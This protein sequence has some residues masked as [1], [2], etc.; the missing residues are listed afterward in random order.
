[1]LH[2]K[3]VL[4]QEPENFGGLPVSCCAPER[5][6]AEIIAPTTSALRTYFTSDYDEGQVF[7]HEGT[8]YYF[9][10]HKDI[11][12]NIMLHMASSILVLELALDL[13]EDQ[14]QPGDVLFHYTSV[15]QAARILQKSNDD[16]QLIDALQS[17]SFLL[18]QGI[19]ACTKSPEEYGSK[20]E[21]LLS[22]FWPRCG[23]S[24]AGPNHPANLL[25]ACGG[26]GTGPDDEKNEEVVKA[27]LDD[28]TLYNKADCCIPILVDKECVLECTA[29]NCPGSDTKID[30]ENWRRNLVKVICLKSMGGADGDRPPLSA[31]SNFSVGEKKFINMQ[32]RIDHLEET[33]GP[34]SHQAL[35]QVGLLSSQLRQAGHDSEAAALQRKWLTTSAMTLGIDHKHTLIAMGNLAFTLRKLHRFQEA[36][37][38]ERRRLDV[39]DRAYGSKHPA[40]LSAIRGLKR[41]LRDQ[42]KTDEA[43]NLQRMEDEV[44]V[45][46]A[47]GGVNGQRIMDPMD[48]NAVQTPRGETSPRG[49]QGEPTPRGGNATPRKT[50]A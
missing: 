25:Q 23:D 1:M 46:L 8:G 41:T 11:K 20:K 17:A 9:G 10:F 3:H 13:R 40:T 18:R 34:T 22:M 26:A 14:E 2:G 12:A 5:G 4:G 21:V 43:M 30:L 24:R 37:D 47:S 19:L 50:D 7:D 42:G 49:E 33:L 39:T 44:A 32:K 35:L 48:P 15:K 31:R 45:M 28:L 38:L 36:E 6:S 27:I 16:D 29:E